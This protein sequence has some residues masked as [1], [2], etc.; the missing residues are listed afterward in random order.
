M[1]MTMFYKSKNI[2]IDFRKDLEALLKKYNAEIE[3][4]QRGSDYRHYEVMQV[5]MMQTY[6]D[7]GEQLTEYTEFDL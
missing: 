5:T 3:L 6:T 7:S 2:E 4:D 1:F